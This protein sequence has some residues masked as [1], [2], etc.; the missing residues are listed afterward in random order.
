MDTL[1]SVL[2]L[3]ITALDYISTK[4]WLDHHALSILIIA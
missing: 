1:M 2:A 3:V 4:L